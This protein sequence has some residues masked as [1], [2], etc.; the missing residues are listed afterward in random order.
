[1][2]DDGS[3]LL[4]QLRS[5]RSEVDLLAELLEQRVAGVPSSFLIW[6]DTPAESDEV[7]QPHVKKLRSRATASNTLSWRSVA[8]FIAENAE[9]AETLGSTHSRS[10][11]DA[12]GRPA[13]AFIRASS[14]TSE[15]TVSHVRRRRISHARQFDH[16]A[17]QRVDLQGTAGLDVLQHRWLVLADL[18]GPSDAFFQGTRN[19]IP[20]LW[21]TAC[22]SR[23][24][25]AARI[26][27]QGVLTDVDQRG[28]PTGC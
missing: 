10:L 26:A 20:S 4:K 23:I 5:G 15:Y 25:A 3:A 14:M 17:H 1:L 7:L 6:V 13:A 27:R 11:A 18:L 8:F 21:A 24:I 16:R 28:M 19:S 22:A 2:L 12:P 9:M